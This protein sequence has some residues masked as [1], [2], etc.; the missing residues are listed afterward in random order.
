MGNYYQIKSIAYY[1]DRTGHSEKSRIYNDHA[2]VLQ[3]EVLNRASFY[4]QF[5]SIEGLQEMSETTLNDWLTSPDYK[6]EIDKDYSHYIKTVRA[7]LFMREHKERYPV[8]DCG[9][10]WELFECFKEMV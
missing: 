6:G 9:V 4:Y 8:F 7:V 5:C 3:D 1:T 2:I 10:F